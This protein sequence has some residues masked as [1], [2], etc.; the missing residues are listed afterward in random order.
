M[1]DADPVAD[2]ARLR[3]TLAD[4]VERDAAQKCLIVAPHQEQRQGAF[5]LHRA[6]GPVDAVAE[7]AARGLVMGALR[8]PLLEEVVALA[9]QV[10]PGGVVG[11]LW[12]AQRQALG[13]D[14]KAGFATE[15]RA[16]LRPP[17]AP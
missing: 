17:A 16:A 9:A 3:R 4:I 5:L 7:G 6:L 15:H 8:L 13:L 10:D 1:G 11:H 2:G 14:G 12:Q